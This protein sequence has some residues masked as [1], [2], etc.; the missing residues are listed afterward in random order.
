M[1]YSFVA[2]LAIVAFLVLQGCYYDNKTDLYQYYETAACDTITP[3]SYANDIVP[4]LTQDCL[5]CHDN[6]SAPS[7]GSVSLEGYTNVK[8]YGGNGK[9]YGSVAQL[10][11]Y[12][13]M[14]SA[15]SFIP[16]CSQDKIKAWIN[17]GMPNN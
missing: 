11:G 7:N 6:A 10:N 3:V 14:P 15:G 13:P 4:I 5:I 17:A 2:A 16:Q 1:K 9:L 12:S 8:I